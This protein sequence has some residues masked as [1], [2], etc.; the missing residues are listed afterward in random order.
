MKLR[1]ATRKSRL[2]LAQTRWIAERLRAVSADVEVEEVPLS[3]QGDEIL[4]KPLSSIGGKGLF[5]SEVEAAIVD[6]R[7]DIAVH[8][9]KDVPADLAEG[10]AI[11]AIPEREDARDCFVTKDGLEIDALPAGSRIGTSSLRRAS[12]LKAHRPDFAFAT[13]RGNVD[14]R[15][16][17]LDEGQFDGIILAYA[18]MLRLDLLDRGHRVIPET[19]CIPAVGQGALGVEARQDDD[20][21]IDLV[22]KL[23][24]PKTRL[25]VEAE[26]ALLQRLEGSCK[27]PVAGHARLG[28]GHRLTLHGMVGA[29]DGSQI[30]SGAADS[31]LAEQSSVERLEAAKRT[32][33]QLADDL[34]EQGA[35]DLVREA[36]ATIERQQ[37]QGNG[38]GPSG[39]RFGKWS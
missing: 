9:M 27:V 11:V 10:L 22:Q 19:I 18:G 8:S 6:G 17:K 5:V 12:Q 1:I 13:L 30:I 39:G 34:I 36:I 4:D 24:D 38:S 35:M 3:T 15:L 28:E 20:A 31:Y 33:R 16:R 29:L 37:K 26:R 7:A 2:A 14:T 23:D 32:G 21:V 25:E